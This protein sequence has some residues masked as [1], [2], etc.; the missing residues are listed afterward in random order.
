V[1]LI[2]KLQ[3]FYV[4]LLLESGYVYAS[5]HVQMTGIYLTFIVRYLEN[6]VQGW[7]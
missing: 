6:T 5:V 3:L 4:P 7:S 1:F 2:V